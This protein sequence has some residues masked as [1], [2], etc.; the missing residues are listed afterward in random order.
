MADDIN[1]RDE[2]PS[3]PQLPA[4]SPLEEDATPAVV[5]D[6]PDAAQWDKRLPF[7]VA[8]I[9][10]SAGGVEA[11]ILLFSKL[12]PDTGMAFV[13]IPHLLPDHK[14]HL[15]EILG[16]QSAMPI[17][18]IRDGTRPEPNHVYVLPPKPGTAGKRSFAAART[19]YG[20]NSAAHRSFFSL[21]GGRTE[22]LRNRRGS[23]GH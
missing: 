23:F 13:V 15:V 5:P 21:S 18:E 2:P 11:F 17:Q 16:R 10:A 6:Q 8:G 14:S 4:A 22:D 12:A 9:G 3:S 7:P 20:R 1:E 19:F